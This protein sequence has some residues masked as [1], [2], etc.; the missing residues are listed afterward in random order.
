MIGRDIVRYDVY[1][2]D[3]YIAEQVQKVGVGR[4]VVVSETTK[5]LL[6]NCPTFEYT[7]QPHEP[8]EIKQKSL[9][10]KIN[11]YIVIKKDMSL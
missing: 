11:T 10:E 4:S 2:K 6:E 8:V 1:G 5:V 7:F 9:N 3:V